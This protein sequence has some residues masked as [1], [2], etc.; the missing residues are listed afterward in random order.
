MT[1][2]D[3]QGMYCVCHANTNKLISSHKNK[4]QALLEATRLRKQGLP[5]VVWYLW[6]HDTFKNFNKDLL[7]K[8]PLKTLY[9][10]RAQQLRDNYD[11]LILYYSGGSDSHN[12]L[13]TFLQNNIC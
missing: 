6:Y 2:S 10:E 5:C 8:I 3:H 4:V 7:G 1:K 12:I 11:E 9:K 13:H